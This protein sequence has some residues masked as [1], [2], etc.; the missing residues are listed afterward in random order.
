MLRDRHDVVAR[1]HQRLA[2][3]LPVGAPFIQH[4]GEFRP[5]LRRRML[6]AEF[7]L[8]VAP[9]G[10]RYDGGDAGVDAAAIDRDRGPEARPE[11]RDALAVDVRVLRQR[12]QRCTRCL[13]LLGAEQQAPLALALA[14]AGH[15]EAHGDVTELL[16]HGAGREHVA[17]VHIAAEAVQHDEGAPPLGSLDSV[18]HAHGAGER[19]ALGFEGDAGLGH[20]IA[21][22]ARISFGR[23]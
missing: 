19:E 4:G 21:S 13:H 11:Q 3:A 5:G 12:R 1:H 2:G 6:A 22:T 15:V 18:R 17:G 10:G 14:A 16:E 9:A 8:A 20:H 23:A 7:R